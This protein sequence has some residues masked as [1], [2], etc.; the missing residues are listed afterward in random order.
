MPGMSCS[1]AAVVNISTLLASM[2]AVKQTYASFPAIAYRVSK[3]KRQPANTLTCHSK[4]SPYAHRVATFTLHLTRSV[5]IICSVFPSPPVFPPLLSCQAGLNM[6]T[7]CASEEL[8]KDEILFSMLHPGWVR[9]DMGG[10]DVSQQF[11]P[12]IVEDTMKQ[13]RGTRA[14]S[15]SEFT[16]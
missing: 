14:S 7:L 13:W 6:L 8:K 2:E 16:I 5:A 1:K 12:I 10:E 15:E 4:A 11:S 3:V 9:T